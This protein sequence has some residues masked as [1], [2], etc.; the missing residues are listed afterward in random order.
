MTASC[1]TTG[2]F[3]LGSVESLSVYYTL[4]MILYQ[5]HWE[6]LCVLPDF[7]IDAVVDV[8][9]LVEDIAK[10]SFIYKY[11]VYGILCPLGLIVYIRDSVLI[12]ILLY[13]ANRCAAKRQIVY[14]ANAIQLFI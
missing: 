14:L 7:H 5:I 3:D 8:R 11:A 4:I 1:I 12:Q 6:L 10:T 9:F 13:I 2:K